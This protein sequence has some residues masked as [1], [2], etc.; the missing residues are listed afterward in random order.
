MIIERQSGK[1]APLLKNLPIF[2]MS[3]LQPAGR[4]TGDGKAKALIQPQRDESPRKGIRHCL[5]FVL[6]S[7]GSSLNVKLGLRVS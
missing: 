5:P 6:G 3:R 7:G 2:V 1:A 4:S